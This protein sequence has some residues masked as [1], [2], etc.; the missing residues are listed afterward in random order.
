MFT[1][2]AI[3]PWR[4]CNSVSPAVTAY[5]W[6][7]GAANG[8]ALTVKALTGV[9]ITVSGPQYQSSF[10][11]GATGARYAAIPAV[12]L[13]P[14]YT[15]SLVY[16]AVCRNDAA[17]AWTPEG[18]TTFS[19]NVADA[20][21]NATYGTFRSSDDGAGGY[22]TAGTPITVGASDMAPKTAG[23]IAAVEIPAS[24]TLLEDPSSPPAVTASG[25]SVSTAHFTPPMGS[26]L[27]AMVAAAGTGACVQ[28]CDDNGMLQW[29]ELCRYSSPTGGYAG[30]WAAVVV[31][32]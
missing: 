15:G 16:G 31:C 9:V 30:V 12:T 25:T 2:Q 5:Q 6:G 10:T 29:T 23:G 1:G 8:M 22:T 18:G 20:T 17:S 24:G 19:Q 13:V 26:L 7:A 11:P 4:Q 27:V 28:L 14:E 3:M 21:D 32:G